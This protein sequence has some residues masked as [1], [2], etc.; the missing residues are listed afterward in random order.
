MP[1]VVVEGSAGTDMDQQWP[2]R[3]RRSG[4]RRSGVV[5]DVAQ[6][7]GRQ[8]DGEQDATDRAA[9]SPPDEATA[10]PST[11]YQPLSF[12]SLHLSPTRQ[13]SRSTDSQ[14]DSAETL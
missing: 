6:L 4:C 10:G 3:S 5:E 13:L 1:A 9:V 2:G 14:P 12:Y 8:L 11:C 7:T